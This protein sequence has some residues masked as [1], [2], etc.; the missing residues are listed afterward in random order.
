MFINLLHLNIF[1]YKNSCYICVMKIIYLLTLL[2]LTTDISAKHYKG[3]DIS[4][5][6]GTILWKKLDTSINFCIIKATE[7]V[8]WKDSKF[9]YNWIECGK[10]KIYRGAYHYF[11][12]NKSGK[13]QAKFFLETVNFKKGDILPVI[14]IEKM[15]YSVYYTTVKVKKHGK[16]YYKKKRNIKVDNVTAYHNL[17]DMIEYIY[18]VLKV[19][20]IIYTTTSHWNSYYKKYYTNTK[21]HYLWIAD[22]RKKVTNPK[23]PTTW[24]KWHIWQYSPKAKICGIMKYVDVNITK[25]HPSTFLLKN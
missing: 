2:M 5:H 20:P 22:Y 14:D 13:E 9:N 16:I 1:L 8:N 4:H 18:T 15:T 12:P 21:H 25:H 7:G 6:Q 11:R 19:K 10:T 17:R 3:I 24:D 23:I